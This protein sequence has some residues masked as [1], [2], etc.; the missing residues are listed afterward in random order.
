ML[1]IQVDED[2][3]PPMMLPCFYTYSSKL[4]GE[5]MCV[6]IIIHAILTNFSE[7]AWYCGLSMAKKFILNLGILEDLL[8]A[9]SVLL[10]LTC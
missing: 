5:F 3:E 10:L 2:V 9:G 6:E 4:W 8:Y 7:Y 1:N